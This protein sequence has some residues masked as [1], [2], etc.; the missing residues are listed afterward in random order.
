VA[1]SDVGLSRPAERAQAKLFAD[2]LRSEAELLTA[3]VAK[4]EQA[5]RV[6]CA[7]DGDADPPDRIAVVKGRIAEIDRM[8][9]A[10]HTRFR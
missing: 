10:L 9:A 1:L 3:K 2:M 6:K 7:I 8:I 4:A 5:W